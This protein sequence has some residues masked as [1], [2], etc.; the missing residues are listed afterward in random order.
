MAAG[1]IPAIAAV[2]AA[3]PAP[4]S[5]EPGA[6]RLREQDAGVEV[7]LTAVLS[8]LNDDYGAQTYT[9]AVD[10]GLVQD[11]TAFASLG[12]VVHLGLVV[13][14]FLMPIELAARW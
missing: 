14:G 7:A 8:F 13:A 1:W 2:R 11:D 10:Q 9:N 3:H 5:V 4:R 12:V 6:S